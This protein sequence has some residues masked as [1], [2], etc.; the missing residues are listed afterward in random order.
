MYLFF[1]RH[2]ERFEDEGSETYSYL[3]PFVPQ[4]VEYRKIGA[5]RFKLN[6]LSNLRESD[7]KDI[8]RGV[9]ALLERFT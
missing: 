5:R 3:L 2:Y 9:E 8:E 1:L 7:F 4:L 6:D